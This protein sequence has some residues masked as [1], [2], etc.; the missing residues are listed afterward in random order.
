M[1]IA[2]S[3]RA[4]PRGGFESYRLLNKGNINDF[5]NFCTKK[6]KT[7]DKSQKNLRVSCNESSSSSSS[8]P[9]IP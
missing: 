3:I 9:V 7:V 1:G 8:I 2:P 5:Q 6:S 4:Q